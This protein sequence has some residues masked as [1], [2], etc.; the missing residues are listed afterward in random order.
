[1]NARAGDLRVIEEDAV[2]EVGQRILG[3]IQRTAAIAEQNTRNARDA[4]DGLAF[5]LKAAEERI[6][7]LETRARDLEGALRFQYARADR[8][9]EWLKRI[10]SEIA[11][12]LPSNQ[13]TAAPPETAAPSAVRP[14]PPTAPVAAP[15]PDIE[16]YVKGRR[17]VS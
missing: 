10:S 11:Q 13:H 3:L 15:H 5:Q 17:K 8:A 6:R 12:H 4:A 7:D 1:M 2:E 16:L 14:H 9:E